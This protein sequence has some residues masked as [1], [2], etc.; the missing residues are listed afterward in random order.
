MAN[1]GLYA[2]S[3]CTMAD[4][5]QAPE[6]PGDSTQDRS[7]RIR[8]VVGFPRE[9]ENQTLDRFSTGTVFV[10]GRHDQVSGSLLLSPAVLRS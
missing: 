10:L 5:N 1:A 6:Q 4:G 2:F 3:P 8:A 9:A 7:F